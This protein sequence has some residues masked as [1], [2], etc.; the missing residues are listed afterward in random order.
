MIRHFLGL[1]L[2]IVATLAV[3]SWA[4]DRFLEPAT[5]AEAFEDRYLELAAVGL[6]PEL[7][8]RQIGERVA[9]LHRASGLDLEIYRTAD[10]ATGASA[11]NT[12]PGEI[13]HL[14]AAGNE[15]WSLLPIG[16]ERVLVLKTQ[17][18][19]SAR[20]PAEWALTGLFYAAIAL[21][22][23]IW[24]WPL[25]RDLSR[26]ERAAS[27]YG[28]RNW[29]FDAP[30]GERSQVHR[31]ATTFRRMAARIDGLIASHRDMSN[32]VSHEIKTPLA[33][34]R[35]EIEIAQQSG[36]PAAINRCFANLRRD[37]TAVDELISATLEYAILERAGVELKLAPYD[38]TTL[39]PPIA[40]Q[41]AAERTAGVELRY[42]FGTGAAEVVC[43]LHLMEA[44]LRNL[45]QNA[46]RYARKEVRIALAL[47]DGEYRLT[48]DDDGPGIPPADRARV[49]NSFVQLQTTGERQGHFGLGLAIVRRAFEWHGGDV[50][51]L[52]SPLGG[53]RFHAHWPMIRSR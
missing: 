28:N 31:L 3:V 48:V 53:A 38:F 13:T 30:I 1:F 41:A 25:T 46:A 39:L 32:A 40:E 9:A 35:F 33:R 10:I 37:I 15:W 11:L 8:D 2:L 29:A 23:M 36:D 17:D 34:M 22:L 18:A 45:V 27:T 21:V 6:T 24:L 4:Q 14:R 47:A 49:F 12:R 44:A 16:A 52:D 5:G 26:L 20:R 51:A 42:E 43:D 50:E 7:D 19:H